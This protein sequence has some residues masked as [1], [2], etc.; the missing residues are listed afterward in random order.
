[1]VYYVLLWLRS[2]ATSWKSTMIKIKTLI[3]QLHPASVC[4]CVISV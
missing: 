3:P 1:M 2:L 4:V